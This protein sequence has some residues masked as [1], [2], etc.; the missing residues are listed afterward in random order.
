MTWPEALAVF[1]A[2]AGTTLLWHHAVALADSITTYPST[3]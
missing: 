1:Y 3:P 2:S